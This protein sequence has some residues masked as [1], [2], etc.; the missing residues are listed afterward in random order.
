MDEIVKL[1]TDNL[2]CT[3]YNDRGTVC[4]YVKLPDGMVVPVIIN[5]PIKDLK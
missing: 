2:T 4:V 1:L 5:R 3:V